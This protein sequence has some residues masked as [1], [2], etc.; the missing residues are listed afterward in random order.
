MVIRLL[1]HASECTFVLQLDRL[2]ADKIAAGLHCFKDYHELLSGADLLG[3]QLIIAVHCVS[4]KVC[5]YCQCAAVSERF[6]TTADIHGTPST[7][8][9]FTSSGFKLSHDDMTAY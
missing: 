2:T 6:K 1:R 8:V 3:V 7:T 4:H 9:V 5:A